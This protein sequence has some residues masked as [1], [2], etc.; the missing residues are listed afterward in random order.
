MLTL[1]LVLACLLLPVLVSAAP[2]P[3]SS[4][5]TALSLG[6]WSCDNTPAS[7]GFKEYPWSNSTG[8]VGS[9]LPEPALLQV[10]N[11]F[12]RRQWDVWVYPPG[13]TYHY[14]W[15]GA[16]IEDTQ[17]GG[18]PTGRI[19][20]T[21]NPTI[22]YHNGFA[23]SLFVQWGGNGEGPGALYRVRFPCHYSP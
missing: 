4:D 10:G 7:V 12:T 14:R 9:A 15:D 18:F 1:I 3:S 6:G 23:K 13:N 17:P 16:I 21:G 5:P 2:P 11:D 8:G 20:P 19:D 22:F